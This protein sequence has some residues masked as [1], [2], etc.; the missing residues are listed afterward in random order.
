MDT[1]EDRDNPKLKREH[2]D[3]NWEYWDAQL[4]GYKTTLKKPTWRDFL[5]TQKKKMDA[6]HDF[7]WEE[8]TE[9]KGQKP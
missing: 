3:W 9:K 8:L 4:T 1:S 5:Q 2:P 7:F 6:V